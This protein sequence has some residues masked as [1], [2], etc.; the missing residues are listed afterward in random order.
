M[1]EMYMSFIICFIHSASQIKKTQKLKSISKHFHQI[2]S[3]ITV[4]AGCQQ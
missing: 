2:S 3:N 1:K 4:D